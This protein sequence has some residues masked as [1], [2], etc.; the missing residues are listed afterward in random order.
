MVVVFVCVRAYTLKWI[1][2]KERSQ[3]LHFYSSICNIV[4]GF[5]FRLYFQS[6]FKKL[7]ISIELHDIQKLEIALANPKQKGHIIDFIDDNIRCF[8][9]ILVSPWIQNKGIQILDLNPLEWR[10]FT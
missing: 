3:Y 2:A 7:E 6:K 5:V 8:Q 10:I 4:I 1:R 9:M